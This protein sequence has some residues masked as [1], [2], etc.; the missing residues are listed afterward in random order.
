MDGIKW[1]VTRRTNRPLHDFLW[2][3][4][5]ERPSFQQIL[6]CSIGFVRLES[7]VRR[8]YQ[9]NPPGISPHSTRT[10][11]ARTLGRNYGDD[12]QPSPHCL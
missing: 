8:S 10:P 5:R 1:R 11:L 12:H 6:K 2:A 3:F 4:W 7:H 9:V